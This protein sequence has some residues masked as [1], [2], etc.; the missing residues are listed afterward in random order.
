MTCDP[1]GCAAIPE[2]VADRATLLPVPQS[3]GT[4]GSTHAPGA[5][6]DGSG[7]GSVLAVA[8]AIKV[9]GIKGFKHQVRALASREVLPASAELIAPFC[10][11]A[12]LAFFAGEEQGLLGSHAHFKKLHEQNA[13]VL[14]HIQG[15]M[16]GYHEENE[17][18]QLGFP[19]LCVFRVRIQAGKPRC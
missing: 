19:E 16:L 5:D 8:R 13:T 18:M 11:Q 6:D 2:D 4:F 15:D 9:S 17:P 12:T 10:S 14:L 7:S 1:L 3:R